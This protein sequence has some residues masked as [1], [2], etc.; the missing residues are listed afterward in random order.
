[1]SYME[2]DIQLY[3]FMITLFIVLYNYE[4]DKIIQYCLTFD[5]YINIIICVINNH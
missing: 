3:Y 1:M 2:F 5:I 4:F